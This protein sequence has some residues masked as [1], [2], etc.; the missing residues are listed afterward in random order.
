VNAN[1]S[2]AL[3]RPRRQLDSL[4]GVRGSSTTAV[5]RIA[6]SGEF[7]WLYSGRTNGD[8]HWRRTPGTRASGSAPHVRRGATPCCPPPAR[9]PSILA[10]WSGSAGHCQPGHHGRL[11]G[12]RAG[13]GSAH[14]P[15]NYVTSDRSTQ[16]DIQTAINSAVSGA[17]PGIFLP[18]GHLPDENNIITLPA[19]SPFR[20]RDVAHEARHRRRTKNVSGASRSG[21]RMH[22]PGLRHVR[23]VR[24][25]RRT[26]PGAPS[27]AT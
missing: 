19:G 16:N 25:P 12:P 3:Q 11:H 26:A 9:P 13:G 2:C 15:T 14:R 22:L 4:D 23:D 21:Q 6:V 1:P 18:P 20:A 8:L 24:H 10:T 27:A 17:R 7:A 5:A